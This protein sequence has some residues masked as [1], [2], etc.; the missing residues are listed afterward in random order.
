M[1]LKDKEKIIFRVH[2]HWLYVAFP[3]FVLVILG[4]IFLIFAYA[5]PVCVLIVFT[6]AL[7]FAML[8]IFLDWLCTNYYLTNLRLIEERGIIGK[9]IMFIP[10]DRVQDITCKFGVLGKIFSFGD[11][12]IESAGTY[13]KIIFSFIPNPRRRKEEI[14]K[15]ILEF[16]AYRNNM[17]GKEA[18]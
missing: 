1:R 17:E 9:R 12:E 14:N 15:A 16:K 18:K 2:P 4:A 6:G 13:G 10:L 7:I 5:L 3:E 8:M 11:L